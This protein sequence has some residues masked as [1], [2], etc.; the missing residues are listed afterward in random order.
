M[1]KRLFL[2]LG[3]TLALFAA[4]FGGRFS[5]ILYAMEHHYVPPHPTVASTRVI[6]N[7]WQ[8]YL[9][10]VG[11]L[12]AKSGVT[13]SNEL[14]GKVSGLHFESG[15]TVEA[16]DL[17]IELDTVADKAEL[18]RLQAGQRLAKINLDRANRLA[19]KNFA[20]ESNLDEAQAQLEQANAAVELQHALIGKKQ[21]T[22]P[23]A[24]T[25]GIREVDLGQF[26]PAGAPIVALQALDQ[27]Y[28]DFTL[29][30][31]RLRAARTGLT[32]QISVDA[33]PDQ[34]F[35]GIISAVSP[36]VEDASRN[37]RVRATVD[38]PGHLLR[39]GMFTQITLFTGQIN[40]VLTLPDTAITYTT[41]GDSVFAI[42][43]NNEMF[44]V[45]RKQIAT[46]ES[47]DGRVEITAGLELNDQVVSAG[48]IKLRD[49]IQVLI[50]DK[51]APGERE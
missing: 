6:S 48:Q 9:N 25:L 21:I 50:S 28:L 14:P 15:D 13:V 45:E 1:N 24:G 20:S 41:Y 7:Q 44:T 26:L 39:P 29:P 47:R 36:Q 37:I 46:G 4:L 43:N 38:N 49:G 33:Y 31:I 51:P 11:A 3:L 5:Q 22:A 34:S 42:H 32:V 10:A 18:R 23:F 17:L 27:L 16:G 2:V 8:P 12:T 35:N 19:K 30:E 40:T